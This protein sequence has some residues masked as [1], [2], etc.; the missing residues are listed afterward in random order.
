M[1][2]K[3]C[4]NCLVKAVLEFQVAPG[5]DIDING[6]WGLHDPA[7]LGHDLVL[8][9]LGVSEPYNLI[10]EIFDIFSQIIREVLV[11]ILNR[12]NDSIQIFAFAQ[13]FPDGNP[14]RGQ[15]NG[16]SGIRVKEECPV[17][18]LFAE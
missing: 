4:P 3:S 15:A 12:C 6:L 1:Y 5:G 16:L 11:F 18:K 10:T 2:Q 9:G 13:G 14:G 7:V 17:I 8:S